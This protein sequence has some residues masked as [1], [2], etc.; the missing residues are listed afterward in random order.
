MLS[1]FVE[2]VTDEWGT[3][4][5]LKTPAYVAII[6]A[7]LL[8]IAA[9]GFIR[10]G[11][12]K[13]RL[14]TKQ[15][16]FSS[17]AIALAMVTSMLK[18]WHMPMGGSITLFSMLFICL[19]G[20]WYGLKI[21]LMTGLAY[22]LLQLVI[23]PYIISLPQLVTDY[24]LAFG[25]LGFSGFFSHS[26]HGLIKGYIAG[27]LGRLLFAFLSGLIF[28][29]T[30]AADWGMSAPI[31]SLAYNGAYIGAEAALTLLLVS[32][33]PVAKALAEIKKIAECSPNG[34]SHN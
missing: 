3:S 7:I 24:L 30:Y 4:Y 9:I 22:G 5:S 25:A 29:S 10:R 1:F 31:Y 21:G 33:P 28:F 14:Q 32:M 15:L 17:L 20:Y 6:A 18:L 13:K 12:E 34:A 26:K 11:R 23:E 16:V 8:L 19:I 27:V 2:K